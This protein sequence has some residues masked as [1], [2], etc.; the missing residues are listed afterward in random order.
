MS[1]VKRILSLIL[2]LVLA[3]GMIPAQ[4]HA[5][6]LDNGLMYEIHENHVEITGYT[7]SATEF[8]IPAEIAGKPVT[9]I[10]S[11]AFQLTSSLE[12]VT[13]PDSVTYIGDSAFR[14]CPNLTGIVIPDGVTYIGDSAFYDC[15]GITDIVIPDGV[16]YI[17]N[18]AFRSCG[19]LT[20][21]V[22]PDSIT[23]IS[24]YTFYDCSSLTDFVIPDTI[25][26]IGDWAFHH[27]EGLNGIVI[28]D[29]VSSIGEQAFS[30][31]N[32]LT[33]IIIP[34]GVTYMEDHAF[35]FCESLTGI[36]VDENNP[37]YSSDDRGVLFDKGKT[38][39]ILAPGAIT[40]PYVIPDSVTSIGDYAFSY[41]MSLAGIVIPDSVTS[42]GDA[43]FYCCYELADITI[44]NGVTYFGQLAFSWCTSLT[45]LVIPGSVTYISSQAFSSSYN[46]THIRF[47]GDPPRFG[48]LAF[49][50]V[51]TTVYYPFDNPNWTEN[52]MQ[53]Y[54]GRITWVPFDPNHIHDYSAVVTEPTCTEQGF[55]TYTCDCGENYVVDYVDALGHD[56]VD[57]TC[58]RCGDVIYKF[59]YTVYEN[60][61]EITGGEGEVTELIIPAEIEGLPVTS[62][63]NYAFYNRWCHRSIVIPDSVT[64]IG[65][66]AFEE[67]IF[68]EIVI[69][70]SVTFI[71][72]SAFSSCSSLTDIAIPDSVTFIGE[73]AFSYC[74]SLAGIHVD[75]NNPN[76][77]NDDWGVLFDKEKT[78]LM[79]APTSIPDSYVI[80]DSV[81]SIGDCAFSFCRNLTNVVLPD[82]LASI[83]DYA[84]HYCENLTDIVIPDGLTSIGES[85]FYNCRRLT[86]I[87]IPDSVTFIGERAFSN[88][89][90][91]AG[92]H[93]DENNP[94]YSSDDR[95]VL[96]DKEKTKLIQAPETI[97]G[98]YV[99]PDDVT[100]IGIYAFAYCEGLADITIPD[101]VTYIDMDAFYYCNSLTDITI[102]ESV[103]FISNYAFGSC[104]NL[105]RIR[106]MGDPP[107]IGFNPLF[108]ITAIAYYPSNN[109]KWTEF[110]RDMLTG[111]RITW[112]PYAPDH[113]HEYIPVVTAPTCT[114]EG[115]TTY[116]CSCG[117]SYVDNYVASLWHQYENGFC[118]R[119]GEAVPDHDG[120][121]PF[122][123]VPAGAF[124]EES[125]LWAVEKGITNGTSE[126]SFSPNDQCRRAH[127]VTFLWRAAGCPEPFSTENPFTDVKEGDFFFKPVLWAVENAITNGVSATEFGSYANCNRAAVVTFLWRAA[128][129]PEPS[130]TNNPFTDVKSTDFFYKPVLWAVE[131]G[132]T[133]GLTATT[134]GPT[135][136]CNRAQVVTFL[137][138]AY[139]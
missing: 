132:I 69:P 108:G 20:S 79:Q 9:V 43:V 50:N 129:S 62:I 95:G 48:Y 104:K 34:E 17:G 46:L 86:S 7:G 114:E 87:T 18:G 107:G 32:S 57:Y 101:G 49:T 29:S 27:C 80:P 15:D 39:L 139:N 112:V 77:S 92:I 13:I 21:I 45:E 68:T 105:S 67:C 42:I 93:V 74:D 78:A 72:D 102:P 8:V 81:T 131:N 76:Y 118:K 2:A 138:R 113:T 22:I 82:N 124:Y 110:L 115:F 44:G 75:E 103:T 53:G 23:F 19:N 35:A 16:T 64:H 65:K 33:G 11:N 89:D 122:F 24:A 123:D 128:G 135:A 56:C 54:G 98:S 66:G 97:T 117:K 52:V 126:N 133:A 14:S 90:S 1:F 58:R 26:S 111:G 30:Y 40:D 61:V 121:T 47:E 106:F 25:T 137:Y 36:H 59:K 41:C 96:F 84:F 100:L 38:R 6:T 31:C 134:F 99:I 120:A 37:N 10:G 73:R 60:Y 70:D 94:N 12:S 63:G 127:V 116:T 91:L 71:G 119:C 109:P 4:A 88:C 3:A 136:E 51:T 83:G 28:P 125:V 85:A 130:S 5:A 55:T